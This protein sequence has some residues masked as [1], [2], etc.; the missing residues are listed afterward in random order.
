MPRHGRMPSA[1][2]GLNRS[3]VLYVRIQPEDVSRQTAVPRHSPTRYR[4]SSKSMLALAAVEDT[5]TG[6]PIDRPVEGDF[7]LIT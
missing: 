3:V 2:A 6:L 5:E 4:P 1:P 7:T